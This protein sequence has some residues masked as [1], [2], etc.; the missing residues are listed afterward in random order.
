MNR[1][2]LIA[3]ALLVLVLLVS[4]GSQSNTKTLTTRN[5]D[6]HQ[7]TE[8]IIINFLLNSPPSRVFQNQNVVIHVQAENRGAY[9]SE[10]ARLFI[11]GFERNALQGQ[12]QDG[13]DTSVDLT[14]NGPFRGRS[15]VNPNG[16]L[17][18]KVFIATASV[19]ISTADKYT[20]N[21]LVTSCYKYKT[22]ANPVVCIDPDPFSVVRKD[23]VCEIH[24]VAL[25]SQGAPIAVTKVEEE[26]GN[27]KVF[28]RIFIRNMG[29]GKVMR[30]EIVTDPKCPFG[31]DIQ[32]INKVHVN[33]IAIPSLSLD[34]C[35]PDLSKDIM[36]INDQG[37]IF[38]SFTLPLD[39]QQTSY[40]TPLNIELSYGYTNS[41]QKQFEIVN[42]Q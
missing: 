20:A 3:S 9:D 17:D 22:Q 11:S 40:T 14:L 29:N 33:T 4:C 8:G 28:F 2:V 15:Q 38:C 7:G 10:Y 31:L 21:V 16:A 27:N 32:D 6:F 25:T 5:I 19:P 12:W 1:S 37:F 35:E 18:F 13:S 34:K 39:R 26:V 24:D 36:L 23:K 30:P 42:L 41:I